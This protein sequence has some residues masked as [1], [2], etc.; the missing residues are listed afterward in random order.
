M[1]RFSTVTTKELVIFSWLALA[2][3]TACG[4]TATTTPAT[5][6]ASE[7]SPASVEESKEKVVVNIG[8][9][10]KVSVLHYARSKKIFEDAFAKV[11]ADVNWCE[12]QS[13]PP[14]FEAMASQRLDLGS[15]GGTP[16]IT[17]QAAN[18]E[19]KAIAVTN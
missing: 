2:L 15:V 6:Q 4:Q 13:G 7:A 12:F 16:V 18:I 5:P 1:K 8:I 10:G 17:G 11:G 19:F 3:L 9:Q 14:Y